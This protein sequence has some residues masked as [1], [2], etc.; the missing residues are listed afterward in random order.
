VKCDEQR[1]SCRVC[2]RSDLVCT[3]F[4]DTRIALL[5]ARSRIAGATTIPTTNKAPGPL[6]L[7][8]HL[9]TPFDD[10]TQIRYFRMFQDEHLTWYRNHTPCGDTEL[11]VNVWVKLILPLMHSQPLFKH[12]VLAIAA[13]QTFGNPDGTPTKKYYGA[14]APNEDFF[15]YHYGK[16]LRLTSE[17]YARGDI[18]AVICA[19]TC[20]CPLEAC[21]HQP[22]ALICHLSS[23]LG[24]LEQW[25]SSAQCEHAAGWNSD[26]IGRCS[27][28]AF[29]KPILYQLDG[30]KDFMLEAIST[31]RIR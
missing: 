10:E 12:L 20:F 5:I 23:G 17:A 19:A 15:L 16:A 3:Y 22:D 6:P 29:I 27:I 8:Q 14:A 4:D 2:E 31:V 7:P 1:P 18:A 28:E 21:R 9:L 24:L 25:M 30:N 26:S 11:C 13:A